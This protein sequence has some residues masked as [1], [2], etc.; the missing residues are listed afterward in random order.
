MMGDLCGNTVIPLNGVKVNRYPS[1][2]KYGQEY[3]W[4]RGGLLLLFK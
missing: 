3:M 1:A 4:W 2:L